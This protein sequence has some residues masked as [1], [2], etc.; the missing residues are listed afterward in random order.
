VFDFYDIVR[1]THPD[2]IG[3][4]GVVLGRAQNERGEWSYSLQV[5]GH[6]SSV[7]FRETD[8]EATGRR[9]QAETFRSRESVAVLVDPVSGE[10]RLRDEVQLIVDTKSLRRSQ[11]GS[12]FGTIFLR[13]ANDCFPAPGW[14]D[15]ATAFVGAWLDALV[16]IASES[17]RD[18]AVYLMDGPYSIVLYARAPQLLTVR[19]FRNGTGPE[20][21]LS[22]TAD[23]AGLLENAI[24]VGTAIVAE[25]R[26][27]NWSDG[28]EAA[29]VSSLGEAGRH[30]S[31]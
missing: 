27:R 3:R 19:C 31:A 16:K 24:A 28:D 26:N 22:A 14:T 8:L 29:L 7:H 1:I 11:A 5:Y 17:S 15:L 6:E 30:R 25:Y 12:V 18:E 21:A 4:E 9:D 13:V 2:W 10:G 20:L 23:V